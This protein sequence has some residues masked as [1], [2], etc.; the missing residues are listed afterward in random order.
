MKWENMQWTM[1]LLFKF[2][3]S[4]GREIP[5][6]ITKFHLKKFSNIKQDAGDKSQ[7]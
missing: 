3:T 4:T 6:D 7:Q 2:T 5:T 1:H